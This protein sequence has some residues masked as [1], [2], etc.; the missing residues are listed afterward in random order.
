MEDVPSLRQFTG[1]TYE[2]IKGSGWTKALHPNDL[3]Q[4]LQAWNSAV[5]TRS[6]YE[7]EYR[8]RR[9]DGVYRHLLARGFPVFRADGSVR[10]WVGTCLDITERK[11]TEAEREKLE[12]Q[13]RVS[14]KMEAIGSLA[15]GVAHDFNNLL[16]V[17]L[18]YTEF[19]ME[20]VR[21]GDPLRTISWR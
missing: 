2:E 13:L 7:V 9:Q 1:Q 18:S 20:A 12:E 17:I 4:A 21:D 14:Q 5:A 11:R 8:L 19:A 6:A 16:S 3:D 10:E 15:G